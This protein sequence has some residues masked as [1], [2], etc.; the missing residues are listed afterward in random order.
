MKVKVVENPPVEIVV[1]E[2]AT[3]SNPDIPTAK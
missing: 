2:C 1:I 3:A